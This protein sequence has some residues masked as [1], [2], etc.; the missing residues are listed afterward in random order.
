M[1]INSVGE[2]NMINAKSFIEKSQYAH[3]E[4]K[5]DFKDD[6]TKDW[7]N[8]KVYQEK[9][10]FTPSNRENLQFYGPCTIEY[11]PDKGYFQ[12]GS[13]VLTTNT[14][15]ENTCQSPFSRPT[16]SMQVKLPQL[17]LSTYNRISVWIYPE[18]VGFQNFY[19]HL[20]I[21]NK[22]K[23]CSHA[24][25]LVANEWNRV[26]WEINDVE[27]DCVKQI[28]ITLFL[29]GCPPEAEP[30]LRI[31]LDRIIAEQVDREYEKGWQLEK[32]IAYSHSGYYPLA[33]KIALTQGIQSNTFAI[34][35]E[36]HQK[37]WEGPVQNIQVDRETYNQL[38]FSSF[39][40]EGYYYLQVEDRKTE[41]FEISET[42]Y[43]NAIWKSIQFLR[44][45]RCGEDVAGVHSACHLHCK[46]VH[47]DG[48]MV[49][50]HG[51]WHDAGDVSQ[52]EICTAEMA[53]AIL[54]LAEVYQESDLI[55]SNRLLEEGKVGINW[56]LRTRFGDGMRAMA[57]GYVIWR[58][59]ILSKENKAV[60]NNIAENGPFENFCAA[61]AEAVA[62]RLFQKEDPVFANWCL[63][64]AKEDFEFAKIGYEQGIY[65]K[66]WGTNIDAQV[67]GEAMLAAAELY[68][69]T[70]DD[71]YIHLASQYGDIVLACQQSDYPN[72][73]TPIRGFFYEDSKHTKILT[74]EHRG[75]E[76]TPVQGLARLYEVAP[77][78]PNAK[79][80][81]EGLLLYKE[82]IVTTIDITAPYG[83]LPA[84]IY[85]IHKLN[86]ERFTIPASHGTKEEGME[87][88]KEQARH[89]RALNQDVYLRIF[90]I[91]VQRR[92]FHATLLSKTKAVSMIAKVLADEKLYQIAIDQLE[93][94]LGKNPFASSTMY[95]EGHHC[96]PLYVAFSKQIVG[97]LPVGI[98]TKGYDDE[99]YWPTIT[100]AVF[101]EIWGHTTGK[102]LWVL[103]DLK[104]R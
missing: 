39:K 90:P 96:H 68:V 57:V 84:H 24:P 82:Y 16:C 5:I 73:N 32:R 64:A 100:N 37:V 4:V 56:L 63:R 10:L 44:M 21:G 88:L 12:E 6:A 45:L 80:W 99:P 34:W 27:R 18:A 60:E 53:H 66:R 102:F 87:N 43:A 98:Q 76:Q 31:Y 78:H 69:V 101:K 30:T 25:S 71:R 50:N 28:R 1:K 70:Q 42:P 75:H 103:A 47:P 15:I 61:A 2:I 62:A 7:L 35:N 23:E 54:D 3:K 94:I 40:Q 13:I 9:V 26:M 67:C 93:W 51:G 20:S 58:S 59:N 74:Y 85:D 86:V 81:K 65:T 41:P 79:K 72:W 83:L 77:Y 91:A 19:F 38:D 92:G 95:G 17:D 97:A 104:R 46:T 11:N 33:S 48:R 52:F 89:G 8:K 14:D 29:M 55:L 36:E 22:G 49:P